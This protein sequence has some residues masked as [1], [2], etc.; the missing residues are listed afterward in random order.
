VKE[1]KSEE[2]NLKL[3]TGTETKAM[4][5]RKILQEEQQKTE[6]SVEEKQKTITKRERNGR[7]QDKKTVAQKENSRNY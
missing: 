3:E 1:M 5:K 2:Q 4:R 6:Q 7:I